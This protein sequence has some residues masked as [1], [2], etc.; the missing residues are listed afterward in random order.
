MKKKYFDT[1]DIQ[2]LDDKILMIIR[3]SLP[4]FPSSI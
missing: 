4:P 2:I 3:D 1:Y